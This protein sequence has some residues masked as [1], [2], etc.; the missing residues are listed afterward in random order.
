MSDTETVVYAWTAAAI[1]KH[2][3][4]MSVPDEMVYKL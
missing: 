2:T 1:A 3:G 4:M